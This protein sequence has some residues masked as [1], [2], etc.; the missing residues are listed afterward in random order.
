MG[1]FMFQYKILV[2][3]GLDEEGLA[4][5]RQTAEVSLQPQISAA[6][7][8][9]EIG[10]YDALVV[11]SRTRVTAAVVAAGKRLKLIGRAGVGVDN[12]DLIA[13]A[14]AGITV[15]NSPLAATMAVAEMT[16]ALMLG[17]AR[18]I[19]AV[20]ASMKVG[21]WDK[22]AFTGG[23]L[24][25]K[26]LGIVGYG[27]VGSQLAQYATTFGMQVLVYSPSLTPEAIR[28]SGV[29]P[30]EFD[31]LLGRADYL[32]LH[33][34]YTETTCNLLGADAFA[35]MKPG[36]RLVNTARGG[37]VDEEALRAAL[38][39]GQVAGAAL[40]VFATEPVPTGSIAMHPRVIATPHIA[41]QTEE[42][43]AR[44]GIDIAEEVLAA[45]QGQTLRWKIC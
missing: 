7:L 18:Q 13:A 5:L 17:L 11:R 21:K 27:R 45:L 25:G 29:Q 34:P 23:E 38:D 4:L 6:D 43:Q 16:M 22:Q 26:V 39:S 42:A 35:K 33:V 36:V 3:D 20:D 41:A 2:A 10:N 30:V 19:P 31:E 8:L 14:E 44:A 1:G 15:V 12:I 40:D 37:I 28:E 32:S 24:D 9:E